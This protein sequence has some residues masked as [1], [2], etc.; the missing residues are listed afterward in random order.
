MTNHLVHSFDKELAD[1][2]DILY[3]MAELA[4]QELEICTQ[5]WSSPNVEYITRVN[6]ID[7][8]V[9]K[10]DYSLEQKAYNLI[11]LRQP[12]GIDLRMIVSS[13][14]ISVTIER[15]GD[16][17]KNMTKRAC[18]RISEVDQNIVK[19]IV[20]ILQKLEAIYNLVKPLVK[21]ENNN[22]SLQEVAQ[23]A[24]E[25]IMIMRI[26]VAK[27]NNKIKENSQLIEEYLNILFAIKSMERLAESITKISRIHYYIQTG[28]KVLKHEI[29]PVPNEI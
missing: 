18:K 5:A 17:A 25:V 6:E 23:K 3:N 4:G 10:L 2:I 21:M 7:T 15:I 11:A 29:S 24:E 19:E 12:V 26:E 13:L 20:I 1:L 22:L 16:L 14:R 8:N 27:L 9:N 28:K